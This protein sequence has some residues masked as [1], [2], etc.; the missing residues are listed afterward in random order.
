MNVRVGLQ[1]HL[2]TFP[3]FLLLSPT[4]PPSTHHP[5]GSLLWAGICRHQNWL[6]SGLR[7]A[8]SPPDCLSVLAFF[9][10]AFPKTAT[11]HHSTS[12][13]LPLTHSPAC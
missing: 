1:P 3:P 6:Y 5:F 8:L 11:I 10:P 2:P 9:P 4:K 13:P 12:A 7:V